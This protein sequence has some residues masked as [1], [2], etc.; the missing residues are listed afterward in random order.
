[1]SSP[2][3]MYLAHL[4]AVSGGIEPRFVPVESTKPGMKSVTAIIYSDVPEVGYITGLTYGLSLADHTDWTLGKPELCI[5][6][7]SSD[8]A[9]PLAVAHMAETMRGDCPFQ[10][11]D[12]IGLG[13]PI[14]SESN[15]TAF[16]VFAPGVLPRDDYEGI[17]VGEAHINIAGCYPIYESERQFIQEHGLEA[18]WE[19]D[20]DPYDVARQPVA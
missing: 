8:E 15:M 12:T 13:G 18:F 2:V 4:D 7:R 6:V 1:M 9:W 14:S 3:E 5:S 20:W 10:Y 16:V 19:L 11:G 17:H